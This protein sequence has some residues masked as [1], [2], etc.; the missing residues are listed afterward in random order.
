MTKASGQ[1]TTATGVPAGGMAGGMQQQ[2][3]QPGGMGGGV[4]G[5]TGA[6]VPGQT[7]GVTSGVGLAGVGSTAGLPGVA[8]VVAI[9]RECRRVEGEKGGGKRRRAA[10]R[11]PP[12]STNS[13]THPHPPTPAGLYNRQMGAQQGGAYG[14]QQ[15]L[16]LSLVEQAGLASHLGPSGMHA[17]PAMGAYGMQPGMSAGP[18]GV[19]GPGQQ[20]GGIGGGG[21]QQQQALGGGMPLQQQ[22]ITQREWGGR[23]VCA[24]GAAAA[25]AAAQNSPSPHSHTPPPSSALPPSYHGPQR[26]W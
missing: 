21:M 5:V 9:V 11:R 22:G 8:R 2:P 26:S 10:R 20:L 4:P 16:A 17:A 19:G 6:S 3:L 25:A 1:G 23:D 7:L 14:V 12:S 15:F 18:L 13:H 24:V